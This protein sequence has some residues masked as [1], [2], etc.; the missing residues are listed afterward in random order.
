MILVDLLQHL[1]SLKEVLTKS[2]SWCYLARV[3]VNPDFKT[4]VF[5]LEAVECILKIFKAR[6]KKEK[7]LVSDYKLT[8]ACVARL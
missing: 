4:G 5:S 1:V 7:L 2:Q 8:G 3:R 6:K